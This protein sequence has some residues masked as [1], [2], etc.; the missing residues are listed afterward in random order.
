MADLIG[1]DCL[2]IV[3]DEPMSLETCERILRAVSKNIVTASSPIRALEIICENRVALVLAD[4]RMPEMSGVQLLEQVKSCSPNTMR[5]LMTAYPDLNDAI[6]AIND[7]QIDRYIRK[8]FLAVDLATDIGRELEHHRKIIEV[9]QLTEKLRLEHQ[10][11]FD[12][13]RSLDPTFVIPTSS[14]ELSRTKRRLKGQIRKEVE[15]LFLKK[16]IE[17]TRGE[18]MTATRSGRISRSFLYKML[19]RYKDYLSG[20][21][22]WFTTATVERRGKRP[23]RIS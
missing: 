20:I 12:V 10:T 8:P 13:L 7:G 6:Q 18:L 3:D 11:M 22:D 19:S 17:D 4:Q 1:D 9:E 15:Q 21:P 16:L 14:L 2:V 23:V 5:I